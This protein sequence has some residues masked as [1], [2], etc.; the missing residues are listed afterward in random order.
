[1]S[2][3][4]LNVVVI[5]LLCCHGCGEEGPAPKPVAAPT[6]PPAAQVSPDADHAL[7]AMSAAFQEASVLRLDVTRSIRQGDQDVVFEETMDFGPLGRLDWSGDGFRMTAVDGQLRGEIA[8]VPDRVIDVSVGASTVDSVRAALG[9]YGA[10][11]PELVMAGTAGWGTWADGLLGSAI[12]TPVR[13]V[14]VSAGGG[15]VRVGFR[16]PYGTGFL[17]L[18]EGTHFPVAAGGLG[19]RRTGSQTIETKL[20]IRY[21]VS[22]I[23][24]NELRPG[25]E[26]QGRETVA[27][28][29]G[30]TAE[31]TERAQLKAGD[32]LPA[33]TFPST[34]GGT[35]DS[36][37]LRGSWVVVD[38]WASWCGPCKQ[39]LPEIQKLWEATGRNVEDVRI[40]AVN[41]MDGG[42]PAEPRLDRIRTYW[43]KEGFG[44]PS[45]L[46][47]DTKEIEQWGIAAIPVT[48]L[49]GPDGVVRERIDGYVPG[50]WKHLLELI[51][52]GE[53][54]QES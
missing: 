27:D 39:G 13:P 53:A 15:V 2:R 52:R 11:A 43:T 49:I 30:L 31:S 29:A 10:M 40:F 32:H 3:A 12:G 34:A 23:D 5:A 25:I 19:T 7:A 1:M 4:A 21:D 6:D 33:F 20:E 26:L 42:G 22:A 36:G 14:G 45:L 46:V 48:I 47:L 16:G 8:Q 51:E 35:V 38:F 28:L 17:E 50:E 18:D 44:F 41:V 37:S 9:D 24:A 54:D